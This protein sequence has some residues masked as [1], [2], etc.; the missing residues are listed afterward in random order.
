VAKDTVPSRSR[1]PLGGRC[2][3]VSPEAISRR[4][5]F[6]RLARGQ[7]RSGDAV[8]TRPNPAL[9]GGSSHDS[10]KPALG[11]RCSR[12]LPEADLERERRNAP[13]AT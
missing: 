7:P 1:P 11:G 4:D 6:F 8:L 13:W 2:G 12:D 3:S 5:T 9:G 10:P